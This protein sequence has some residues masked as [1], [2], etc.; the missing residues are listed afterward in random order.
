MSGKG[1]KSNKA[2]KTGSKSRSARAGLTLPVARMGRLLRK[3]RF[4]P[5]IG[6]AAPVFMAAVLEYLVAELCELTGNCARDLPSVLKMSEMPIER[7]LEGDWDEVLELAEAH[8]VRDNS[9]NHEPWYR[10]MS[11]P[12][13]PPPAGA[14]SGCGRQGAP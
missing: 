6:A 13:S 3:G 7:P 11:R 10:L 14:P 5:R 1:M 4:A 2:K 9:S 12:Q 8:H